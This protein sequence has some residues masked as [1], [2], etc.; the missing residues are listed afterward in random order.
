MEYEFRDKIYLSTYSLNTKIF[1]K[2]NF[3]V[4]DA[5]PIRSVFILTTDSGYKI[6]KKIDYSIDE[7]M[8]INDALNIIREKYPYIISYKETF[9]GK[10]YVEYEG[11]IYVVLDLID[12]RECLFE[13]PIDLKKATMGLA[14]LHAAS[15]GIKLNCNQR[16]NVSRMITRYKHKIRDMEK[17][18]AIAEMHVNKSSFDK[19]YL[20]YVDHNLECAMGA[21]EHIL[22]SP[23]KELSE[24]KR[25]LC[26]HDLA[27]HNILMGNDNNVYFIDFDYAMIDLPYHDVSNIITKAAKNNGWCTDILDIVIDGYS[28]VNGLSDK[29]L[30][31]LYGYLLFPLDF[32]DIA[33]G[34]YMRTKEWEEEDFLEKLRRK[35]GYKD[36]RTIFLNYYKKK[37]AK[38]S[39]ADN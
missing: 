14:K 16:N 29:E 22:K 27:H 24:S 7:L 30:N 10:P 1:D 2:F 5:A 8:F 18:K 9:D 17:F 28:E 6:L 33:R 23:Y 36:E 37:W 35:A 19:L 38:I 26:H 31:V 4:E 21:L 20:E 15:Q 39:N 3:L 32:Y 34:Y 11:G 25:T 12:G 13:N